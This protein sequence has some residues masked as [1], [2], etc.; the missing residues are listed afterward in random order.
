MHPLPLWLASMR[1]LGYAPAKL[2]E[3]LCCYSCCAMPPAAFVAGE[4]AHAPAK[5]HPLPLWLASM[6]THPLPRLRTCFCA[7][8]AA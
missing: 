6:R 1:T 2:R 3:G 5:L 4:Y 8:A 7:F